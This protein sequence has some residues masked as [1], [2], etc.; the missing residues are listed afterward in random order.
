MYVPMKLISFVRLSISCFALMYLATACKGPETTVVRQNPTPATPDTVTQNTT[1]GEPSAAFRQIAIGE[2][3]PIPTLD[4]LLAENASTMRALQLVYEGLVRYNA[5]GSVTSGIAKEWTISPDS[6]TYRFTLRNDI[7]YHDSNAFS[8]GIG[9]KLVA[10]D[11]KHAFDRMAKITVPSDAARLF[12]QIE[13]FEPYYQEQHHVFNPDRRVLNGVGG[14]TT[15]DDSTVVFELAQKDSNFLQKL[16]SPYAVI[17]P[18]EAI[19]G[20]DPTKFKAVGTGP[21]SLSRQRGDS[22]YIFAR[23]KDYY[24]SEQPVV[25]RVDVIVKRDESDLFRTFA[26]GDVHVI[27]EP[28]LQIMQRTLNDEGDLNSSYAGRYTLVKPAGKTKYFLNF[29]AQS[30]PDQQKAKG[31]ARLF[32]SADTFENLPAG[33]I[34]FEPYPKED[35]ASGFT[36]GNTLAIANT[37]DSFSHQLMV[38]LRNKLQQQGAGLQIFDIYTPTRN[39]GLYITHHMPFYVNQ[40]LEQQKGSLISFSV[41]HRALYQNKVE[42]V[43]FNNFPWWID[44]RSATLSSIE[45]Q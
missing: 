2:I 41:P 10:R 13:G 17:Y 30:D 14:I 31:V 39:T 12:M 29:N 44:L 7:Y 27:P 28:G 3:N 34:R 4:P 15:P 9:R 6:L 40:T 24:H 36:S 38:M 18:R 20:N 22:L 33:L 37:D 5:A 8:N 1:P 25:N 11:V 45:N 16:A 21:F 43:P 32:D 35:G 26:S 19:T 23:F 42:G